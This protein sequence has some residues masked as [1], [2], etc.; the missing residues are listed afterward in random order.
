VAKRQQTVAQ[1]LFERKEKEAQ[2]QRG[3]AAALQRKA[4]VKEVAWHPA[5]SAF[6]VELLADVEPRITKLHDQLEHAFANGMLAG[7]AF[8]FDSD[9]AASSYSQGYDLEL[10]AISTRVDKSD[11]EMRHVRVAYQAPATTTKGVS[12]FYK[13]RGKAAG[14]VGLSYCGPLAKCSGMRY[15]SATWANKIRAS[16]RLLS[17]KVGGLSES[18]DNYG[19]QFLELVRSSVICVNPSSILSLCDIQVMS[20]PVTGDMRPA[21]TVDHAQRSTELADSVRT[22]TDQVQQLKGGLAQAE[23]A[24]A[25]WHGRFVALQGELGGGPAPK[26]DPLPH[27][28]LNGQ[29]Y[30]RFPYCVINTEA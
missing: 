19:L 20:T 15:L 25:H 1:Q 30:E 11:D 22:L 17:G 6:L 26:P 27:K 21:A 4:A 29:S 3:V 13:A 2:R 16:A 18:T 10:D 8:R 9:V 24:K 12:K 23:A 14:E 5:A 7:L 28:G